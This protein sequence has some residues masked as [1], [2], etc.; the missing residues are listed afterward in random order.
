MLASNIKQKALELGYL[1]CGIIPA[2]IFVEYEQYLDERVATFPGSKGLY[3]PL[4]AL[5]RPPE[6]AKSIIVCTRR[7]NQY[8][9]PDSL[10]GLYGKVYLFDGRLSYSSEDKAK[11]AFE[12]YFGENGIN[13]M[14]CAIP[15]RWAAVKAG[16]GKFGWNNFIYDE[17]HGSYIWIQTWITDTA[18][19]DND[20]AVAAS[21]APVGAAALGGP[22]TTA[23]APAIMESCG[24]HCQ[25]CVRAC[26]THALSGPFSMD[27]A[28]CITHIQCNVS[29]NEPPDEQTM[30]L[31]GKWLYGC[32]ECQDACPMNSGKCAGEEAFPQLGEIEDYLQ[33]DRILEMDDDTYANIVNPRFWYLGKDGAWLWKCNALRAMIN[34]GDSKYHPLIKTCRDHADPRIRQTAQWGCEKLG[35]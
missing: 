8:K 16:L 21:S 18:F 34:S 32:D 24:E 9:T 31:M 29:A 25:K 14:Q 1:A 10:K 26:P 19:E 20:A 33:P 5:A 6:T 7:Y 30:S 3:E 27:R 23:A 15:V 17:T 12:A 4:Y 2:E 13:I 11:S 22:Q 28:K 35:L